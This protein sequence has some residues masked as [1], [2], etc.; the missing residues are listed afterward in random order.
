MDTN[1]EKKTYYV[2]EEFDFESIMQEFGSGDAVASVDYDDISSSPVNYEDI[3]DILSFDFSD[4]A[5]Y[6]HDTEPSVP[7]YDD[8]NEYYDPAEIRK[9]FNSPEAQAPSWDDFT[10]EQIAREFGDVEAQNDVEEYEETPEPAE[11]PADEPA[12]PQVIEDNDELYEKIK[13]AFLKE[14]EAESTVVYPAKDEEPISSEGL[15]SEDIDIDNYASED[16][17]DDVHTEP[18][19][20]APKNAPKPKT[21]AEKISTPFIS[22]A[23]FIAVVVGRSRVTLRAAAD[24]DEDLGAEM[25]PDKAAKYYKAQLG[26][27]KLRARISYAISLFLVYLSFNLPV[28]GALADTGV[29]SA[30][31]VILLL[32]VMICGLDIITAGLMSLARRKPDANT[33]IALSALLCI[34]DGFVIAS[35]AKGYGLPF[36]CVPALTISLSMAGAVLNCRSHRIV[37]NMASSSRNPYSV[38]AE[39]SLTGEGIT[40]VKSKMTTDG[41]V[42]RTE[43]AGPDETVYGIMAPYLIVVSL[44]LGIASAIISKS[45]AS[46]MHI[47]SG[48]FVCAAPAAMLLTYPLPSFVSAKSLIKHG[49]A[50]AGWSGIYDLGRC[51]NIIITDSDLFPKGNIKIARARIFAGLKPE[52]VVSLASSIVLASG[53]SLT[54]AFSE[55]LVQ[56]NGTLLEVENFDC[57]SVDGFTAMVDGVQVFCGNASFMHLM[58]IS[59]PDKYKFENCIY[60]SQGKA[61]CGMFE[62][63][64]RPLDSV[65]NSLYTVLRSD[66]HPIFAIRDFN[67][68]PK[69]ISVKYD[70]PTDGFDFPTAEKRYEL[71]GMQPS[72]NSKPA[73]LISHEGLGAFVSLTEHGKDLYRRI[74]IC[75]ILSV[76][77]TVLGIALMFILS[78]SG[79]M[80]VIIALSYVL[81]WL[82]PII[83]LSFSFNE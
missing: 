16:D 66:R 54:P 53:S 60:V 13:A 45:F 42:R 11:E 80:S 28:S 36:C 6:S 69:L 64:Y 14:A 9:E 75:V 65:K 19:S 3:E 15:D 40:I 38:T 10:P 4:V 51:K 41:F 25:A 33:L 35:G 7:Q 5:D 48:I 67:I 27:L 76:I 8:E 79:S 77:S 78:L 2:D 26:G 21:F 29:K 43:E 23:A 39:N 74:R 17:Y 44:V 59:L 72:E 32:T 49:N 56:G 52:K 18:R 37:F 31:C 68:T 20:R 30:V 34:I 58:G 1:R 47:I 82:I 12:E 50:I 81:A 46:V 62:M 24:A 22:A 73:A 55:L 57:P 71:S 63:E 83:I 61:I 70:I